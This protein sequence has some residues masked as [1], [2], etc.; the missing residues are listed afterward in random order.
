MP[1]SLAIGLLR[2]D[3]CAPAMSQRPTA[4][5][6]AGQLYRL[7]EN[8]AGGDPEPEVAAK[9]RRLEPEA[10]QD[11]AFMQPAVLTAA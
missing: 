3:N 4:A 5:R 7:F 9:L 11:K 10:P 2:D 8:I 1:G 6:I